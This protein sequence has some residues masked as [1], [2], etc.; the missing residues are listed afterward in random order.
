MGIQKINP[1]YHIRPIELADGTYILPEHILDDFVKL[2]IKH[3]KAGEIELLIKNKPRKKLSNKE[4][5]D[6]EAKEAN[7]QD[8]KKGTVVGRALAS[9]VDFGKKLVSGIFKVK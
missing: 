9:V 6:K 4:K 1:W 8:A 7:P 5:R 2:K 3:N